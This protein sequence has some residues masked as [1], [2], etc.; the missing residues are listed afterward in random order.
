M[1]RQGRITHGSADAPNTPFRLPGPKLSRSERFTFQFV[2]ALYVF[3]D[4]GRSAY[5]QSD[6]HPIL[7]RIPNLDE[8]RE[9][10]YWGEIVGDRFYLVPTIG[11]CD[12]AILLGDEA[13]FMA[14]GDG[15]LFIQYLTDSCT[16]CTELERHIQQAI[17]ASPEVPVRW[18]QVDLAT[19][20]Q[21]WCW[22]QTGLL[23]AAHSDTEGFTCPK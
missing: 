4:K 10:A 16:D 19:S 18:V 6:R 7:G 3:D 2:P 14:P 17:D 23:D 22:R 1:L 21:S 15:L 5:D 20:G 11:P 9:S 12:Q 8:L 13:L